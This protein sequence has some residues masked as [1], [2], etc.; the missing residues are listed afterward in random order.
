MLPFIFLGLIFLFGFSLSTWLGKSTEF[1]SV[2]NTAGITIFIVLMMQIGFRNYLLFRS[3]FAAKNYTKQL[4]SESS[5]QEEIEQAPDIFFFF[6]G[7]LH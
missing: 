3:E 1:Y 2:L 4:F 7:R 5:G 6:I